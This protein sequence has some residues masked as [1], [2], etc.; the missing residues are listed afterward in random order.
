MGRVTTAFGGTAAVAARLT[1]RV[2]GRAITA[3]RSH[4]IMPGGYQSS[5]EV[6][7]DAEVLRFADEAW[8]LAKP[9]LSVER[10]THLL[11]PHGID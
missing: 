3:P 7:H 2:L 9:D 11:R 5:R 10:M 6:T 1:H 4:F 8:V